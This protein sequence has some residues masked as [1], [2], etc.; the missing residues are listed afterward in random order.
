MAIDLDPRDAVV[1]TD[2]ADQAA[3]IRRAEADPHRP[4]F[5]F[6]SPA[7][8]LNDPNGVGQ[9][10]GVYHLFYQYNPHAAAH[11]RIHWGHATSR[12]LVTWSDEPVA[13]VPG[14]E[15]PDRG[16]CW[17]G[18]LVD[19]GG[20]PTLVYSGH[21]D[22]EL[23]KACL[24]I[25]GDGLR[26]WTKDPGNPVLTAPPDL[27][28]VAMRDHCIWREGDGWRHLMG[29]GLQ[30]VGGTALLFESPDLHSW[31]FVG[32]LT[33]GDPSG[34]TLGGQPGAPDWSAEVWECPDLFRLGP[35]GATASPGQ[36]PIPGGADVLVFSAW[37]D[38]VTLHTLALTGTYAGA[39]FT[40]EALHR[41]DLGENGY[42]A[43][44]SFIDDA[45]RR[46]VHGWSQDERPKSTWADAGWVGAMALPRVMR[47]DDTGAP[48]Y[49]PVPEVEALRRDH[50]AMVTDPVVPRSGEQLDGPRGDQLD[51]EIDLRLDA[52]ATARLV[53]RATDDASEHTTIE[54][55][56]S[57]VVGEGWLRLDRPASSL[58][59]RVEKRERAGTIPVGAGGHVR[60]RVL[61][62]HSLLEVFAN[63]TALTARVYPTQ[64]TADRTYL[65]TPAGSAEVVVERFDAW[66]MAD[67]W[68]GPRNLWP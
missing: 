4:R 43:P 13:L 19:D 62:D 50:L 21:V 17:S 51:L 55:G 14:D 49:A 39:A 23:Q 65:S 58:D 41:V 32:P 7:G 26:T 11:H 1:L 15:G 20:V 30:G 3:L 25:S 61:I 53:V 8:W 40:P 42:Y 64:P 16:G 35:E 38:D 27:T 2:P 60:L 67:T 47:L 28:L 9:W 63:G 59:P 5:H 54:V 66:R 29:S 45:G 31:T 6:V 46:I 57:T 52:G 18:I 48:A 24:A 36:P 33:V 34:S 56:R 22:G 68:T 12:D 37:A 10:D 44:Q